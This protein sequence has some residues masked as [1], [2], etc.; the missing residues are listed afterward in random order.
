MK[1]AYAVFALLIASAPA[2]AEPAATPPTGNICIDTHWDYQALWLSGHDIVAKQ[3]FGRDHR[4]LKISTTCFDL[5]SSDF[6]RLSSDF[7]CV[8]MGDKVFTHKL[9]GHSQ[10]CRI[11]HV[12]PYVP[13]PTH[14]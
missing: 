7:R 12:E 4:E 13:A 6:I 3:T 9:G 5:E 10:V 8:A 11:S 2:P 1:I 14:G